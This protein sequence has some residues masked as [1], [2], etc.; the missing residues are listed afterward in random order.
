MEASFVISDPKTGKS[1]HLKRDNSRLIG[2]KIGDKVHGEMIDLP[3]FEFEITGGSDFAGFPMRKGISQ[4]RKR[5]L[6][7]SK[8]PGFKRKLH[9]GEKRRITVAGEVIH[10]KTAQINLKLIKGDNLEEKI[11]G[12]KEQ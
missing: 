10:E 7:S 4:Q 8:S 3:G 2:L 6:I 12:G 11:G 5:I 1:Y 9:K